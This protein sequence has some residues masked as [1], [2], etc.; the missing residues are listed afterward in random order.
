MIAIPHHISPADYLALE[1]QNPIRHEYRRG[2]VYAM[3]GGSD[4]HSRIAV[5]LLSLL[6]PHLD[7]TPCRLYN[8]DVKVNYKDEFYYYPDAFVTC[9]PRDREDRY[10]KRYPKFIA[11]VLSSSTEAFD[12]DLKFTDYQ[13]LDSLEEYV[14]I[15]QDTQRVEC[16]RRTATNT[17][18][19]TIY[20]TGDVVTLSSLNLEFAIARLYRGLD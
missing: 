2:L 5:N 16:R 9:D 8:G 20:Q 1:R 10:V 3:T 14:L 11:E 6:N 7:N 17:W 12:R 13:N 18:E 15:S 4:T 19:T